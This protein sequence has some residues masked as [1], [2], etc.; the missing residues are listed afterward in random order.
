MRGTIFMVQVKNG[1]TQ[2]AVHQGSVRVTSG[3]ED[4]L[5][6]SLITPGRVATSAA[7]GE[8]NTNCEPQ[9]KWLFTEDITKPE[10]TA[11]ITPL[12]NQERAL[13][14]GRAEAGDKV[15]INGKPVE[16]LGN[17]AFFYRA[18]VQ[19]GINDFMIVA[20]DKHGATSQV[21]KNLTV[22]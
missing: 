14:Q 17:G 4:S 8:V 11:K 13:I 12:R 10:L 3:E 20:T 2:V 15:T 19:K 1:Q 7:T 18:K 21:K 5:R 16:V 6:E 9:A 22:K